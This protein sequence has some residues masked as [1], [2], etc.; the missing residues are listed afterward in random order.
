MKTLIIDILGPWM[1]P[2][3][4]IDTECQTGCNLPVIRKTRKPAGFPLGVQYPKGSALSESAFLTIMSGQLQMAVQGLLLLIEGP[5]IGGMA[6]FVNTT[7]T[8]HCANTTTEEPGQ[9]CQHNPVQILCEYARRGLHWVREVNASN[10][11]DPFLSDRRE[12]AFLDWRIDV[13]TFLWSDRGRASRLAE[14]LGVS[15]QRVSQWFVMAGHPAVRRLV[16]GWVVMPTVDWITRADPDE[17][18]EFTALNRINSFA[19]GLRLPPVVVGGRPLLNLA[20][21]PD[22]PQNSQP[23]PDRQLALDLGGVK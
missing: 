5:E 10:Q 22:G 9:V 20:A 2:K 21:L 14:F 4:P 3:K 1:A 11:N 8:K 12:Q 17:V 16:P 15:R 18:P 13:S 19:A 7:Q 6:L 23:R